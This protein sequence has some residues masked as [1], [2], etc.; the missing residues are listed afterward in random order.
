[1]YFFTELKLSSFLLVLINCFDEKTLVHIFSNIH[2]GDNIIRFSFV[3]E[4]II[5]MKIHQLLLLSLKIGF[6]SPCDYVLG[7]CL[8]FASFTENSDYGNILFQS[9][10]KLSNPLNLALHME[11][12]IP[13]LTFQCTG[14]CLNTEYTIKDVSKSQKVHQFLHYCSI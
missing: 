10:D 8:F 5:M 2:S 11:P 9:Q 6:F 12:L 14:S 1:M 13:F 3:F 7:K 4:A